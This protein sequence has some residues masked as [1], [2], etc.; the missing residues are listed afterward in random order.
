MW[1]G[2]GIQETRGCPSTCHK[3]RAR[4]ISC[5]NKQQHLLQ[6][7]NRMHQQDPIRSHVAHMEANACFSDSHLCISTWTTHTLKTH[8]TKRFLGLLDPT[9]NLFICLTPLTPLGLCSH[10]LQEVLLGPIRCPFLCLPY[11]STPLDSTLVSPTHITVP[12]TVLPPLKRS[13]N[14]LLFIPVPMQGPKG[15]VEV[16]RKM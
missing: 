6:P 3:Q 9:W 7:E 14:F 4:S 10:Y 15:S 16:L 2:W 5:P 13:M 12:P 8:F 1:R 11:P